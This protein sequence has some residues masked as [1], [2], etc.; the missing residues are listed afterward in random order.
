MLLFERRNQLL[1]PR[2]A[3]FNKTMRDYFQHL[4]LR[5]ISQIFVIPFLDVEIMVLYVRHSYVYE[6]IIMNDAS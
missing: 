3:L 4:P 2:A 5:C 1:L 6:I